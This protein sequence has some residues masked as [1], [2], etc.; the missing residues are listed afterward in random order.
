MNYKFLDASKGS[1]VHLLPNSEKDIDETHLSKFF[2]IMFERQEIWHKRFILKHNPPWTKDEYLKNYKFTNV[3]RE[4]DRASQWLIGNVLLDEKN[5][6][7]DL[8]WKIIAFRFFNQPNTF[9][10]GV[11]LP[12]YKDFDPQ[13][14]WEQVVTYREKWGNP[15]HTAYMM[16]LAFLP[17]PSNW[18]GRGLFKDE[19]Y[20]KH[21][22]VKHH[23][24]IPAILDKIKTAKK[25]EEII[26]ELEKLPAVSTFQSHEFFIDFCYIQKYCRN[27]KLM[28]QFDQ[29]SYTNVGPGASLGL[30]LIFPSLKAEQQKEGIY[31]LRDIAKSQLKKQGDFK[32][33]RVVNKT[34]LRYDIQKECNIT[35]HQIEMWLCE[36]SKYWKMEIKE[37][38]QRSKFNV[39]T[40]VK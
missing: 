30:R 1:W 23:K 14:M 6:E 19:A 3:Y 20:I 9:N 35:L 31:M 34:P 38:K 26:E 18:S 7:L 25:P 10:Q 12:N 39:T 13:K 37:G 32:Y 4:L 17:K 16:N 11:E 29:N 5:S 27:N 22:F 8:I 24:A 28:T 15:W 33:L 40:R 36:Y 21:A 2:E